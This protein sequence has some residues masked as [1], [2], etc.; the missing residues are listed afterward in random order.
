MIMAEFSTRAEADHWA[1]RLNSGSI[2]ASI[3]LDNTNSWYLDCTRAGVDKATGAYDFAKQVGIDLNDLMVVGDGMN[4]IPMFRVAGIPIAIE[5][6]ETEL[7]ELA[8]A[9]VADAEHDGL[10][11][12]IDRYV[13]RR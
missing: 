1:D 4:D 7:L 13:L 12:A 6:S 2:S 8:K 10:V 5:D 3:S 9:T 11:E